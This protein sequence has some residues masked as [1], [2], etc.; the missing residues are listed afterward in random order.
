MFHRLAR[1]VAAFV[2][3]IPIIGIFLTFASNTA[4]AQENQVVAIIDGQEIYMI[5]VNDAIASLAP[6]YQQMPL[7]S[8]YPHLLERMVTRQLLANDAIRNEL[9]K[10][11]EFM[12]TLEGLLVQLHERA[13]I[14]TEIKKVVTDEL[15]ESAYQEYIKTLGEKL[16]YHARHILLKTEEDAD[17]IIEKLMAGGDFVE[18]AKEH[19]TG[20]SG[21]QGGDL[22]F[23]GPGQMVPEFQE[24]TFA[25]KAGEYT[26]EPVKTQFGYHVIKLEE[27]RG[28]A[29]PTLAEAGDGIRKDLMVKA[30][31]DYIARLIS[32]AKIER[33]DMNGDPMEASTTQ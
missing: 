14:A 29:I 8:L 25:M 18:L 30:E 3:A 1:L 32:N 19:S 33:F 4:V 12:S 22:G 21:P 17:M 11:E 26:K 20:P 24:A 15:V 7:E 16:E 13:A 27:V 28:V 10:T 2:V 6:E 9:D 31:S 23:F 5:D